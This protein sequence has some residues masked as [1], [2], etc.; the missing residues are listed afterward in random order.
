MQEMYILMARYQDD[1]L[2]VL[3]H[4]HHLPTLG[5]IEQAW[6]TRE[7][8]AE[9]AEKV[10]AQNLYPMSFSRKHKIA[11]EIHAKV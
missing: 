5:E 8:Y 3:C 9:P 2:T 1:V 4:W 6:K 10:F 11:E 7:R